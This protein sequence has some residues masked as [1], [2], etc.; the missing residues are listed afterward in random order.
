ML[1]PAS[2]TAALPHAVSMQALDQPCV[3]D[4]PFLP[5]LGAGEQ[6]EIDQPHRC[7]LHSPHP[8]QRLNSRL[9][10]ITPSLESTS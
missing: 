6:D 2:V 7:G 4:A 8:H 3:R 1:A 5:E 10:S 9:S